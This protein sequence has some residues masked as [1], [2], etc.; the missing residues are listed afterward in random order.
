MNPPTIKP[1]DIDSIVRAC[2]E[3]KGIITVEE[4]SLLGGLGGAVAEV[5]MDLDVKPKSF[6]RIGMRDEYSSIVGDQSYLRS[7]YGLDSKA[8][9]NCVNKIMV[10]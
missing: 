1:I 8:I 5:C 10:G 7:H 3:T 6:Y 4:N 2:N 9:V